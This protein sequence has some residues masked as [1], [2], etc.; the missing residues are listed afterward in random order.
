MRTADVRQRWI[1]YFESKDHH[2]EPSV[3]LVSPDPSL[4]FT[5]AGMVP[6]IPYIIG[7]EEAP[8][9]RIA[10]VQK[11]I[12][13]KD[14]EEVGKTTRHGTF[15]QMLGN[16]S[17]GDYFKEGAIDFAWELLT[18]SEADGK[19]GLDPERLWVTTWKDDD[20]AHS[21]LR[22]IGVPD[23]HVV[24]LEREENFWDTGQPGPAGPCA[25]WHYDRGPEFGP[26][27]VGGNVDPGGDRYLEIWNLVFDQF[28][29]GPGSGKDYPLIRELDQKAIDTGAGLERIAYLKQGVG[30]M[31]EIDEVFP[32]IARAAALAGKEYKADAE[33]DIR[34]RVI[35]DHVR[36]SMMLIHDGIVPGN[37]GRGYV[38]RRLLRRTVRSM[39]LLGVQ[40]PSIESLVN[41]SYE[42]MKPSYPELGEKID[43]ILNVATAEEDAF[44]RTLTSGTTIFDTAVGNA[45]KAGKKSLGGEDAFKLHDTYGFPIDLTLEMAHEQGVTV[46]EEGFRSLMTEQKERA[47]ADAKAKKG[48]HADVSVY[49][50]LEPTVFR[51]YDELALG[52]TIA[53]VIKDGVSVPVAQTG[54]TVEII[55]TETPFYAESGGQDADTGQIRGAHATL[56]VIDV[57][58]PI[59][60]VIVHTVTVE[61]GEVSTGDQVSAEVDLTNRHL[62]SKAHSATH[63]IHA[64]LH[65]VLG[66]DA[67]QAGSY[68]KPGY[69]RLD[70]AWRQGISGMAREEIEGIANRA[71]REELPVATNVMSLDD[72]RSL[73]AM[74]LFGEKYG[75]RVRV[76]EIGG[77]FSR[78]LCAGTH[79]AN[80][81]QIGLLSVTSEGS[82]GS[83][84]RRIE[85]LV[86][87]DAFSQLAAERA[88]VN[89]LTTTLKARPD[90]LSDR[91][92]S[93]LNRLS[94]AEKQLTQYRQQAMQ[95]VAGQLVDTATDVGGVKLVAH[96][97]VNASNPDDLRTLVTDVRSRLGDAAPTVVAASA[98]FNGKPQIVIA[99]NGPARDLGVKAGDLVKVAA[100]TLGG[101][102]GGK[103]DL[104][105]GGGQDAAK[106]PDAL[107]AI[108]DA[109]AA[110]G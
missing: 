29:R 43:K 30:N 74:A 108:R 42:S 109:L 15:F 78:E 26:E 10:S 63:L 9:S 59:A 89:E 17:F 102:G 65:E 32:V 58:K 57:Q 69:M 94:D 90:E 82:V 76:V 36:S 2:I 66:E 98:A 56:N 81:G 38:L 7:T 8:H 86:G 40:D 93:L 79:V 28:L 110:R 41:T 22:N 23:E 97:S 104:A 18:G 24:H 34:L 64:A 71:I 4:L 80:S 62:A 72:A 35:A 73:G 51:G 85:A 47:R 37:E 92:G 68:N 46:D 5:V 83:G 67:T 75:D 11:C 52:T 1:D 99:T 25:E 87:A 107:V 103:P 44:R 100:Q 12:R 45:K 70:F 49:Q 91:I 27:A 6:F 3:S 61:E 88:I 48:G 106:I 53:A 77:P 20:E 96:E 55:L 31:Y 54:D 19:Y 95:Q 39:R 14:I 84:A 50:H 105:Q 21:A 101:G 60:D 16:F 13:T 33:D